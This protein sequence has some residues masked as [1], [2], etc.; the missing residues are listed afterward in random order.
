MDRFNAMRVFTRIV[1]LES[2]SKAAEDLQIPAATATYTI[3]QLE[4]RLGVRLLQRTTRHVSPTLDGQAYYQRCVR[5][6]ADVEET[7]AGFGNSGVAPRGKLR[8]DLQ[9]TL[10][11]HYVL[12]R[13]KEFFARYPDIE[14]EIGLG[15]RLVDL[16][17]DGVDCVLRVGEL[18][19]SSMVAR[20]VASL[21]QVTCASAGY[22]EQ[23][24]VPLTLEDLHT[25]GHQAVNFF[26]SS[27]GK[28][29]P[30]EFIVDG[31]D[32]SIN[33]PGRVSVGSAEAYAACCAGDL[34]LVQMPRYHIDAQ[35]R[36]GAIRE[37]LAEWRPRPMPV[38]V[39]YP[40]QRQLSPRV[41]VFVD[42]L[43]EVM[44]AAS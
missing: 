28:M 43:S 4:A 12:P 35:L 40:H 41:R 33:L 6:L 7:E 21:Q 14:L 3:K 2:F 1:E 9:G 18:R 20:R 22:F 29:F 25:Q 31:Q 5:I 44:T 32:V 38:S 19:D 27:S 30:F 34:G 26:S 36:S 16:V 39:L 17:R 13:L 37:V 10:S 24:G 15:D 8:I 42:W 23:Y 11:R